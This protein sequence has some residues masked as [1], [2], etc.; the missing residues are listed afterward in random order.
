MQSPLRLL[1]PP[2]CVCCGRVVDSEFALC[3]ECWRETPFIQ[4]LVCDSCGTPLAG[5]DPGEA[6]KCDDCLKLAR[7][8]ARGRAAARYGGNMR[9][10]I[11]A[12]KHGDRS[13]L[14]RP[15]AEWLART[16]APIVRPGMVVVPVPA[17]WSRLFARR[18]NQSA[19]LAQGVA[20][21]LRLEYLPGSLIRTRRTEIQDGKGIEARFANM[22]G[23]IRP[24]PK[25]GAQVHGRRVLV[26]DDVMT[27]GAT[28]AATTEALFDAGALEV[29][30]GAL[31]RVAKDA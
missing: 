2:Q 9:K 26:I 25:R 12:L 13:D 16:L 10:M 31:A 21:D 15:G 17:H 29:H 27:S 11:L 20:R 1:Y 22:A 8:W 23:A 7:P 28:F 30:V 4:G 19:L 24:H 6:V 14:A 18:Y 5:E 3:G